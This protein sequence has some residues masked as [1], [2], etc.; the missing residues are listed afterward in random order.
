MLALPRNVDGGMNLKIADNGTGIIM[1]ADNSK[2]FGMKLVRTLVE[3]LNGILQQQND[4]GT[5]YNI[6]ISA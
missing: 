4:N 6:Q 3:Q 5:T 2:S 1:H